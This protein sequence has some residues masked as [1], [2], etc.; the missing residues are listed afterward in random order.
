MVLR[1]E[2]ARHQDGIEVFVIATFV[3]RERFGPHHGLAGLDAFLTSD[4]A[5]TVTSRV[6]GIMLQKFFQSLKISA[7]AQDVA[8]AIHLFTVELELAGV[9]VVAVV[10]M[11]GVK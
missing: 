5:A 11:G 6:D 2:V 8:D 10:Q 4:A 7:L 9:V 1:L 3:S